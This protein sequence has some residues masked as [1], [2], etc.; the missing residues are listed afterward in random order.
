MFDT[1]GDW[2]V[3]FKAGET[4]FANSSVVLVILDGAW[5]PTKEHTISLN[6]F[7][8]NELWQHNYIY[9]QQEKKKEFWH[10]ISK[11]INEPLSSG[12]LLNAEEDS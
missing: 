7:A 12:S 2:L 4:I 9:K 5:L 3:N 6:M 1:P 10:Y 8:L 11:L